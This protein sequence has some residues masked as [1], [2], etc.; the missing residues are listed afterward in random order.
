MNA[1]NFELQNDDIDDVIQ[2]QRR[3]TIMQELIREARCLPTSITRGSNQ[4]LQTVNT[5]QIEHRQLG[6]NIK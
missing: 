5:L 4:S 1:L 6:L 3:E 2:R